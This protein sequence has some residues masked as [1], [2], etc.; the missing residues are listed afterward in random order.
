MFGPVGL[1]LEYEGEDEAV[2]IANDS[3]YGLSGS[4]FGADAARAAEIASRIETG[5]VEVN[6]NPAGLAAPFGGFKESGLGHELG[7]EGF[8]EFLTVQ[9][10]GLPRDLILPS[11]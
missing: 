9:S 5:M 4:V 3:R 2:A 10:I 7:A 11:R 1:V 8:D 6:G